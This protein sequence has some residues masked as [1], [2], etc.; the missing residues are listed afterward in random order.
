MLN[1]IIPQTPHYRQET[2]LFHKSQSEFMVRER[3][4]NCFSKTFGENGVKN[5]EFFNVHER[6][7][8]IESREREDFETLAAFVGYLAQNNRKSRKSLILAEF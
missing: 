1:T 6:E 3:E 7:K 8:R 2:N 5:L 4:R